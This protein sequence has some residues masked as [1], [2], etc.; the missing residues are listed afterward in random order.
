MVLEK[1]LGGVNNLLRRPQFGR[2]FVAYMQSDPDTIIGMMMIHFETS[3][4]VGGLIWWINSVY[5]HPNYRSKGV[6]RALYNN[7]VGLAQ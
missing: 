5:V 7:V 6:F 1:V 2:Y 3:P 4:E